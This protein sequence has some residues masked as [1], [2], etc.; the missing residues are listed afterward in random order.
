MELTSLFWFFAWLAVRHWYSDATGQNIEI[1]I[2]DRL[3]EWDTSSNP[4]RTSSKQY[5]QRGRMYGACRT[6]VAL[7]LRVVVRP[8][9]DSDRQP[10][11]VCPCDQ[12]Y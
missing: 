11:I 6:V 3:Q 12:F 4:G 7:L 9:R 2:R 8:D 1:G 5:V 10:D